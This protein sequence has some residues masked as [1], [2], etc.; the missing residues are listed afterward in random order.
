[1][2]TKV[3]AATLLD[4]ADRLCRLRSSSTTPLPVSI[5]KIH[6]VYAFRTWTRC[7]KNL[8]ALQQSLEMRYFVLAGT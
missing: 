6:R 8:F 5:A 7:E 2:Y 1:M 4:A 3:L